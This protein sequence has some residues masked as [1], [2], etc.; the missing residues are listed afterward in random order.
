MKRPHDIEER[1]RIVQ[2]HLSR[3][4]SLVLPFELFD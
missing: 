1:L 4:T 3:M 2:R